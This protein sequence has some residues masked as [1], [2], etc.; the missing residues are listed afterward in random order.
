MQLPG[1]GRPPRPR[2]PL[3][4]TREAGQSLV[5]SD[6]PQPARINT[7]ATAAAMKLQT[8][9]PSL[10]ARC[11][12]LVPSGSIP[13]RPPGSC[14]VLPG[15]PAAKGLPLRSKGRGGRSALDGGLSRRQNPRRGKDGPVR[16][17]RGR[18]PAAAVPRMFRIMTG[19][20]VRE[21]DLFCVS[22]G[23]ARA[24]VF[25]PYDSCRWPSAGL[26]RCAMTSLSRLLSCLTGQP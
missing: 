12:S 14:R 25:E 23:Q 17:R 11:A 22:S 18:H 9:S 21:S 6:R 24:E 10:D 8:F 4:G 13:C 2:R 26:V 19:T 3:P 7:L 20:R 5:G 15:K 1:L 16:R